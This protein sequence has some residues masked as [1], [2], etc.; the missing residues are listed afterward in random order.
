M[1]KKLILS[2][3]ILLTTN[4]HA[5]GG[6]YAG[7]TEFTQ[8][9]NNVELVMSTGEL[10]T[11][12]SELAQQTMYQINQLNYIKARLSGNGPWFTK[13][14]AIADL[15]RIV[16]QGQGIAAGSGN[17]AED[18]ANKVLDFA[19]RCGSAVTYG[20][21]S[22]YPYAQ[23]GA[24][25]C[26]GEAFKSWRKMNRDTIKNT[27]EA[28]DLSA[29]KFETEESTLDYLNSLNDNASGQTE[30]I[31]VGNRVA[32]E[33]TKQLQELR[34]M[35]IAQTNAINA[36]LMT[37]NQEKEDKQQVHNAVFGGSVPYEKRSVQTFTPGR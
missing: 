14:M 32:I 29:S 33:Q 17:A 21:T 31:Q 4:A 35:Q 15:R 7:A 13:A 12:T 19:S 22:S 11:Q 34:K 5:G 10:I 8:I 36:S 18:A 28:T 26:T 3:A 16:M 30:V 9:M 23:I 2:I 24:A 27:I 37:E 6:G 1:M 25:R 20:A